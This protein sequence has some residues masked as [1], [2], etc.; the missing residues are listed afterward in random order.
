MRTIQTTWLAAVLLLAACGGADEGGSARSAP[1]YA[2]GGT[3]SGL[4]EGYVDIR[5]GLDIKRIQA[6][7][8][9]LALDETFTLDTALPA[10]TGYDVQIA[11]DPQAQFGLQCELNNAR[12]SMP[13]AAISNVVIRCARVNS[14]RFLAG[15]IT[16]VPG[17]DGLASQVALNQ[18]KWL[19]L[20]AFG[21]LY[22]SER[23]SVRRVTPTGVVTTVG[24]TPL[25]AQGIAA[26]SAGNVYTSER[27]AIFKTTAAGSTNIFAGL[28]SINGHSDSPNALF[29][30][31]RGIAVDASDNLFVV[32]SFSDANFVRRI[33]PAGVVSTIGPNI[34]GGTLEG[35]IAL[36]QLGNIFACQLDTAGTTLRVLRVTSAGTS[37]VASAPGGASGACQALAVD[38][39][40]RFHFNDGNT[41]KRLTPPNQVETITGFDRATGVAIDALG[42]L[43]VVNAGNSTVR[44][45]TAAGAASTYVGVPRPAGSTV[46]ESGST[47]GTGEQARFDAPEGVAVDSSGNVF[48]ADSQNHVIRRITPAGVTSTFAGAARQP[49]YVDGSGAAARFE[50]LA[51][52]VIDAQNN[53]YVTERINRTLRRITPAGVVTTIAGNQT[54]PLESLDGAGT[55]AKFNSPD[56]IAMAPSG[57]L[58]VRDANLVRQVSPSA[59]VVTVPG[60]TPDAPGI[61]VTSSGTLII[62][63]GGTFFKRTAAGFTNFVVIGGT[64]PG[65]P[66]TIAVGP[67]GELYIVA[68]NGN[69]IYRLEPNLL[70]EINLDYASSVVAG[71]AGATSMEL[72]PLPAQVAHPKGI[73]ATQRRVYFSSDNAL[74]FFDR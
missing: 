59:Q 22:L 25:E 4:D 49:G 39:V 19:N 45:V 73:A 40:G 35:G 37:V 58:F 69:A 8:N 61:A 53:L 43:L 18:P 27:F 21:N 9:G 36:D 10:G 13:A 72:G 24:A 51:G 47:D 44:R 70:Q 65:R 56:G 66:Q 33:T 14:L 28:V 32:D 15:A 71:I 54:L 46:G 26:D 34:L 16:P 31:T 64:S 3:V 29:M 42:D 20:D 7:P 1:A 67:G 63:Q 50:G 17:R 2:L 55:A 48:V 68:V 60:L 5:N 11:N 57:D 52:I 6:N 12:G 38:R 41:V 23:S 74:L 30:T 62:S